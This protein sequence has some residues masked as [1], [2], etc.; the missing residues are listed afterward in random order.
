MKSRL[1]LLLAA[2]AQCVVVAVR[3]GVVPRNLLG[4]A[5]LRATKNGRRRSTR[6]IFLFSTL[7]GGPTMT[8]ADET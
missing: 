4:H 5:V 3:F 7:Q 1:V 6:A 8:L 2:A